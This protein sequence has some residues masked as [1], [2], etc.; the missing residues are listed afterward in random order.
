ME[1]SVNELCLNLALKIQKTYEEAVTMDEAEK[2]AAEFLHGQL[3]LASELKNIDLDARMKKSGLKAVKAAVYMEAATKSDKKPS[4]T[5][6]ENVVNLS[7]LVNTA[8]ND[9]DSAEVERDEVQNYFNIFKEAHI[10][11]RGI[12]KGR[13]E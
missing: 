1:H 4:D 8:Q 12:S 10:Y 11:F 13:F 9:L 3:V 7:D 2:L 5:F 6:I